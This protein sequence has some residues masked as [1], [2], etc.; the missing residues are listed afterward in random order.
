[1]TFP[2]GRIPE[3]D[4]ASKL[5]RFA[6]ALADPVTKEWEHDGPV[7]D[8]TIRGIGGCT[9]Y[10]AA[11]F[12]NS[13]YAQE[14]LFGSER[15]WFG[16][17]TGDILYHFATRRDPFPGVWMPDDTGSSGLA[18]CKALQKDFTIDGKT[19][20]T[21]YGHAFG[22]KGLARRMAVSPALIGIP[23]PESMDQ[24]DSSG[25]LR[26]EPGSEPI[27]SGHEICVIGYHT[28]GWFRVKNTWGSKWGG[29]GRERS[30]KGCARIDYDLMG[31]LLKQQGD[32]KVPYL[33]QMR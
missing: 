22:V 7:L 17:D 28:E 14:L 9:G 8:Q 23:W 2:K 4:P 1:M 6:A 25:Y 31:W 3:L 16:N 30:H 33:R 13:E 19:A 18:V 20:A 29:K 32:V 15:R 21:G 24:P 12:L 5:P 10:A 27:E 11:T 26:H